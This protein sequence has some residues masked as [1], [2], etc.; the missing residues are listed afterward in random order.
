M[1]VG[2]ILLV[3]FL[4]WRLGGRWPALLGALGVA[5]YPPFIHSV[6]E[7]M[8]EPP[9]MLSLPAAIL[10]FLWAWDRTAGGARAIRPARRPRR[11][12]PWV[13][14][15]PGFLFGATAMFRPE[16]TLVAAA[17]VVFA[18]ARWAW[19]REWRLGTA[20]VGLM[21]VALLAADRALDDPQHRRASNAWCR[22]RPAAARRSTSAPSTPPTANTQ[23]VK[24]ILYKRET[25][26]S[27]AAAVPGTER[28]RPH[29]ALQ[30]GRRPLPR[31]GARLGAR[32]DRQA[33]LLQVLR[34]TPG[35]LRRDDRAQGRP[36]VVERARRVRWTTGLGRVVQVAPR[37]ARG[38]GPRPARLPPPLVG[39]ALPRHPDRPRHRRRRRD[40]GGARAATR[41]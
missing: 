27:P 13:W 22:S 10:A 26:E 17:F 7:I 33:E 3:F 15:L 12:S 41:S 35:R 31:T 24:A 9:T 21:L 20:A 1:G 6:G 39:D 11:G 4:G 5:I 36:D 16:Y 2:T 29:P 19:E 38:R 23:R 25:G 14:L 30:Q 18:A 40:P 8:S 34:R 37:A 28:S 32:Q